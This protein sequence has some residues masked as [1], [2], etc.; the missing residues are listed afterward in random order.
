MKIS[1][2]AFIENMSHPEN[3]D[4]AKNLSNAL[5]E[6]IHDL[7][8]LAKQNKGIAVDKIGEAVMKGLLPK[9]TKEINKSFVF[10]PQRMEK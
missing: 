10:H 9:Y 4:A 8:M 1:L 3:V 2:K 6:D 7:C 5:I